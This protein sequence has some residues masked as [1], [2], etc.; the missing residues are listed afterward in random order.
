MDSYDFESFYSVQ[1]RNYRDSEGYDRWGFDE[2]V[3]A[4]A[5]HNGKWN[6]V[7]PCGQEHRDGMLAAACTTTQLRPAEAASDS[8]TYK[9]GALP[10]QHAYLVLWRWCL[11]TPPCMAHLMPAVVAATDTSFVARC[12]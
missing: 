7:L 1:E 12:S 11:E 5:A 8:H 6:M 9:V 3:R 2:Q 4:D 10:N